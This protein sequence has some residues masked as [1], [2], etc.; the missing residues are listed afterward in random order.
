MRDEAARRLRTL[1]AGDRRNPWATLVLAHLTLDQLQR[2]RAVALYE[3]AADAFAASGQAEGEVIAR[4]NLATQYRLR[5]DPASAARHVARA[6]AAAETSGAPLVVARAAVVEAVHEM[7]TGG[8]IGRAHRVLARADRLTPADAPIGLRRTILFNLANANLSLNRLDDA[9]DALE[10]HRELMSVDGSTQ[11]AATVAFNLLVARIARSE[12]YP[13]TGEGV[14]LAAEAEA[15]VRQASELGEPLVEAQAHQA[16]GDL[17]RIRDPDRAA[18]HLGRCLDLEATLDFPGLRASCLWSLAMLE[19]ARDPR[20]AAARSRDALALA[21]GADDPVL[22]VY[23]WQALLPLMWRTVPE[24][25][26]VLRSFEALDAIERLRSGQQGQASRAEF[27]SGWAR[28]FQWLAGRLLAAQPS[29]VAQAFEVGERLRA[30]VL[31]EYLAHAGVKPP[32]ANGPSAGTSVAGR[33]AAVQRRLLEPSLEDDDRRVLL[34][35]LRLLELERE[36]LDARRNPPLETAVLPFASLES[37]QRAL[38]GDEAMVWFSLAPWTDLYGDFGGGAWAVLLTAQ[39]VTAHRLQPGEGLDRQVAAFVGLLRARDADPAAWAAASVALGTSLLRDVIAHVPAGVSQLVVVSDGVLHQL[40]FEAVRPDPAGPLL[41]DRFD[42][43]V[44]PS[45][46]LWLR[47]RESPEPPASRGA[48]VLANPDVPP[49]RPDFEMAPLTGLPWAREEAESIARRLGLEASDA[50]DGSA[51]S[52]AFLKR[53]PLGDYG[54]IHLAAH[55]RANARSPERSA[56]FLTPG[57]P[58]EDGWLQPREI[59]ALQFAGGLVVL[60]SCESA[61]GL[62]LSGEGPLSL[63][64]AFFA[65]GASGVV[66]TRWPVRDDDAAWLME[67]LYD[68]LAAGQSAATALRQARRDAQAH[69]VPAA[70]WA[71]VTTLGDGHRRPFPAGRR[72]A[73]GWTGR[74]AAAAFV[75]VAGSA[76]WLARRRRAGRLQS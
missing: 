60:S 66:A 43:S 72:A 46:T 19:S 62:L 49:A 65:G 33:I 4:Q 18:A 47:L 32:G 57:A 39:T 34:D 11:D 51:A 71:S 6:V 28:V 40:P 24:D 13:R 27:L 20:L 75:L 26:A 52:E 76:V 56:V 21:R 67:R 9:I 16:L 35:Q 17:L 10:R 55:A 59:A 23:A 69:G 1:G 42:I 70:A 25:V 48:L 30:R 22:L 29:R 64:R 63:A 58:N 7:E 15:V 54:V 36:E 31:L 68:G 41:G 14:S 2:S 50:R 8:D 3:A 44:V 53:V 37:V 61:D 38:A 73:A 12:R 45:A 74:V 5:S